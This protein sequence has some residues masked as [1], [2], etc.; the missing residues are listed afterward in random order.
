MSQSSLNNVFSFC[1]SIFIPFI[2]C[3]TSQTFCI[4]LDKSIDSK[5]PS[6]ILDFENMYQL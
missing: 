1:F 6:I 3:L 2:S 4:T 5:Y